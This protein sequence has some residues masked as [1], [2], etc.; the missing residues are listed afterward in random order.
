MYA[1]AT[2]CSWLAR[3]SHVALNKGVDA[4]ELYP[5]DL[6]GYIRACA[7]AATRQRSG[8]EEAGE[9]CEYT[10]VNENVGGLEPSE[11][12]GNSCGCV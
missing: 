11:W 12:Q 3:H 7:K 8:G 5:D 9:F 2:R 1:S 6:D 10:V 4:K